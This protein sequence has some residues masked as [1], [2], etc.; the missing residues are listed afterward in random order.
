MRSI[1]FG[2]PLAFL[3][4]S[5]A[6]R[7]A[8]AFAPP[9]FAPDLA[10]PLAVVT[11]WG[12]YAALLLAILIAA[13]VAAG[14][15]YVARLERFASPGA[16]VVTC[17]LALACAAVAPVIF[18]SDVYA[19]AAYGEMLRTG[20]NPYSHALL[21]PGNAIFDA[22]IWQWGNPPPTCVYGP[23][24][25]ALSAAVAAALAPLGTLAVLDGMRLCA[26]AATI[27]CGAL[28][29][30]AFSGDPRARLTA[31]ATIA[32]NPVVI[33]SAVEGHND[34]IALAAVLAGCAIARCGWPVLGAALAAA[35]GS[36]KL[37]AAGAALVFARGTAG[38]RLGAAL[39]FALSLAASIPLLLGVAGHMAPQ[40][41]FAPEGSVAAIVKPLALALLPDAAS[42]ALTAGVTAALAIALAWPALGMLRRGEPELW[43]RLA[44]AAW[45]LIPNP[46]PWYGV[47]L[48]AIA[49]LAPGTPSAFVALA[50]SFF[51]LLRYV[52]DAVGAPSPPQAVALG[53][54][55]TAPLLALL[56]VF[57]RRREPAAQR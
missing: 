21:P 33:W 47:W 41:R 30:A 23:A 31:A 32:L 57:G 26:C 38:A 51:A 1:A 35:A 13:I 3:G 19:Y 29:Y 20:T 34:A 17:A 53:L 36:I 12:W 10:Q 15:A 55:A 50:L 27:A 5:L 9:R 43:P 8:I 39:G 22:A 4:G 14:I 52:P 11:N 28:A 37:P 44:I 25:V 46:E 2:I 48:V 18:S 40:G 6:L 16:I 49:A 42:T 54:A 7:A 45:V 24:F 56:P